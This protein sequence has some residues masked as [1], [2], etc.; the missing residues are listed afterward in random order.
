[1]E[2]PEQQQQQQQHGGRGSSMPGLMQQRWAEALLMAE[3]YLIPWLLQDGEEA[4]A[5]PE[6]ALRAAPEAEGPVL[7][8]KPE[9]VEVAKQLLDALL[10]ACLASLDAA[11]RVRVVH[12]LADLLA[13]VVLAH[14]SMISG[15]SGE[16]R[17]EKKH[18]S[19]RSEL[20]S[21]GTP[22]MEVLRAVTVCLKDLLQALLTKAN[23]SAGSVRSEAVEATRYLVNRLLHASSWVL[24]V[25]RGTAKA[26]VTELRSM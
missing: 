4:L 8:E 13:D 14:A 2:D 5:P 3:G 1:M 25:S 16:R 12:F 11:L 15:L 9:Y 19:N 22:S 26:M 7:L 18:D 10:T 21:S 23:Q 17:S 6:A 24:K 20:S